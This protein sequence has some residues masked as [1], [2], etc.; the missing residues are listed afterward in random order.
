MSPVP[1]DGAHQEVIMTKLLLSVLALAGAAGPAMALEP[2]QPG[3]PFVVEQTYWVK[4]GKEKQF[5]SLYRKT[6]LP[7]LQREQRAGHVAWIRLSE[8]F[9]ASDNA[10]WDLRVTVAWDSPASAQAFADRSAGDG[11]AG[12]SQRGSI[13]ETLLLGLVD[14]HT[15]VLVLEQNQ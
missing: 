6:E 4:P 8:P 2:R 5:V 11:G 15:E 13:E 14:N 3:Q 10:Q 1:D 7:Q 12:Q 9:L